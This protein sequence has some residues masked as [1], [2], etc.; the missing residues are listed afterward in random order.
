MDILHGC[1]FPSLLYNTYMN[2][3]E[4]LQ[5]CRVFEQGYVEVG[6]LIYDWGNASKGL[7]ETSDAILAQEKEGT[8]PPPFYEASAFTYLLSHG[9]TDAKVLKRLLNKHEETLD[10]ESKQMLAYVMEH[11][12]Y[13]SCF[14][15]VEALDDDLFTIKDLLSGEIHQLYSTRLLSLEKDPDIGGKHFLTLVYSNGECLHTAGVLRFNALP[16]SDL[17]FYCSLFHHKADSALNEAMLKDVINRHYLEFF[18]LD[19]ISFA[20][21]AIQGDETLKQM[22]QPFTLKEFDIAKLGGEWDTVELGNQIKYNM[23][24]PDETMWSLPKGEFLFSGFLTMEGMLVR[25]VKTGAMGLST[26]T[27]TAYT[28]NTALLKRSYPNLFLPEKPSVSIS[29]PLAGLLMEMDIGVPWSHFKKII[30]TPHKALKKLLYGEDSYIVPSDDK[31][32]ELT[33]CPVPS[34]AT[35]EL[36]FQPLVESDLFVFDDGPTTLSAFNALTGGKF[37]DEYFEVDLPAFIEDA[38]VE[39]FTHETLSYFLANS[40]F[41]I[42]FHMGKDWH[43]ARSYA[44]EILKLMPGIILHHYE[45]PEHFI[46]DFSLFTKKILSNRGICSLKARPLTYQIEYGLYDIKGSEAFYSLVEGLKA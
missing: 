10:P 2:K 5:R 14:S 28:F 12:A 38:F 39:Y 20:P 40:F 34:L 26:S 24:E 4:L 35:Q 42:L 1:L 6:Q 32:F 8:S 45:K 25:D 17:R 18:K 27:P 41:W 21:E 46:S 3:K 19:T 43:N 11:P 22:W 30:F 23:V 29:I 13:W 44:I 36:F 37:K 16:V 15:V 33:D 9:L 31:T 7:K